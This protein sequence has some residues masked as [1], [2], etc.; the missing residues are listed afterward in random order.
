MKA[1]ALEESLSR[2][3]LLMRDDVRD[4]AS[5]AEM[6]RALT[7]TEIALVAG[8]SDL[9]PHAAQSAFVTAA[10]LMARSGHRVH[11][12]A[13]RT[14][15]VGRQPPLLPGEILQSLLDLDSNLLPLPRMTVGRPKHEVALQILLGNSQPAVRAK[16]T[17]ALTAD[18][19]SA[20]LHSSMHG[21]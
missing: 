7:A 12:V 6:L 21:V 10:I 20:S 8:G 1:A 16:R 4:D 5:P 15:M 2:T 14:A 18:A 11:L 3:L 9:A 19:W 17:I 13:S